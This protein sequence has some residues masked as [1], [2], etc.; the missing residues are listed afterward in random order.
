[1][2]TKKAMK[3]IPPPALIGAISTGFNTVANHI[4]LILFPIALDL[5]LWF[6]PQLKVKALLQPLLAEFGAAAVRMAGPE[7]SELI[8]ATEVLWQESLKHINLVSSIRSFPIGI[9]S[10]MAA[11]GPLVNPLGSPLSLEISSLNGMVSIWL[12]FSLVGLILGSFYFSLL[13]RYATNDQRG[14]SFGALGWQTLQAV[15][16]ILVLIIIFIMVMIPLIL[17]SSLVALVSPTV[18]QFVLLLSSFFLIW[19]LLPLIFSPHGIFTFQLDALRSTLL[20]YRLVRFFLPSAGLFLMVSILIS[21]GMDI[22]WRVA[23]ENSWMALVGVIGHA[24]ISTALA[25]SSFVYYA[26]GVKWMQERLQQGKPA[27]A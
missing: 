26:G 27:T 15:V 23:P 5:L 18:S 17:I 11:S 6:G 8:S 22:L 10:L 24:F 12:V 3:V 14:F 7:M 21:Q 13:S 4:Y 16:L 9:P 19:L 25:T 2:N 1:M 20:S